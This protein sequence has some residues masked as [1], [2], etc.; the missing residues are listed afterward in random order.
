[1]LFVCLN[2]WNS[3]LAQGM[4]VMI[5]WLICNHQWKTSCNIPK[6]S[7]WGAL[8]KNDAYG[9]LFYKDKKEVNKL[10]SFSL[11]SKI[12]ESKHTISSKSNTINKTYILQT[13]TTSFVVKLI[14]LC[15]F[16]VYR[17][18]AWTTQKHIHSSGFKPVHTY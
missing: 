6:C 2:C 7:P 13:T 16:V 8:H 15:W 17:K 4:S 5:L 3:P 9:L 1:M 18:T 14:Q 10:S 12:L 11:S